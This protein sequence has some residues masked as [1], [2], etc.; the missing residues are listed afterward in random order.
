MTFRTGQEN[1]EWSPYRKNLTKP[2]DIPE[3]GGL[4]IV[5]RKIG[6]RGLEQALF[7]IQRQA[8]ERVNEIGG[9][10]VVASM[11]AMGGRQEPKE[12]TEGEATKA[13]KRDPFLG[14]DPITLIELGVETWPDGTVTVTEAGGV[15][16]ENLDPTFEDWL[17]RA[18]YDFEEEDKPKKG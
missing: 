18:I 15:D 3:S 16:L 9:P 17:A 11:S 5:I 8:I 13:V 7:A 2:I 14:L 6:K 1:A 12:E 10:D 4:Q